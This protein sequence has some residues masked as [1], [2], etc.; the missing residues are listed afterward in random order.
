MPFAYSLS[1]RS[2]NH[3]TLHSFP[4]RRSSDLQRLASK[5]LEPRVELLAASHHDETTVRCIRF[6]DL[7]GRDISPVTSEV[8]QHDIAKRSEEHTSELQSP[9]NIV[10]RL[11]LETKNIFT[12]NS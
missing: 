6:A 7:L 5:V 2:S 1:S 8:D 11:L 12:Q 4:T 3:R 10:C 9:C